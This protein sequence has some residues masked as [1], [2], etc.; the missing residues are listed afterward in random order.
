MSEP[1]ALVEVERLVRHFELKTGLIRKKVLTVRAVDDVSLHV[2]SGETL[3]LAGESGS[4]KTTLGRLILRLLTPT[5]GSV[6]FEGRDILRLSVA[7]M[8]ELR[9]EMQIVFQDPFA[10]LNP[11]KSVRH[12]L[13][14]PF[15]LHGTPSAQIDEK[16]AELLEA[17]GL[18]PASTY[19]DRYPH[20]FSGGQRQRIGLARAIALHPKFVVADEPV[21]S[22][23]LSIRAQVL[24]LM[25][26]L[27]KDLGLTYLF[28]THDLAVLRSMATNV[29]IMYL[30]KVVEQSEV[31]EFYS[32]PLHPYSQALLSATP[33][34]DP[35]A[36]RIRKQIK[37]M[38]EIPSAFSLPKGCRFCTRCPSKLPKCREEEPHTIDVGHGH[39]VACHLVAS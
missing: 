5:S 23:D 17:V 22:L 9:R 30:G 34:P 21:S 31:N 28:I 8:R 6:R 10:S 4:G 13:G 20:E 16:V 26:K 2:H 15:V 12:I 35:R 11:R 29:A 38:G 27:Q 39:L 14:R 24:E 37:I 3:G 7:D 32:G 36:S 25:K 19:V 33:L 18:T 1:E